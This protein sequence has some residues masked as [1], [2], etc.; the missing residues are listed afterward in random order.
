MT[1]NYNDTNSIDLGN[2]YDQFSQRM[3]DKQ[4]DINDMINNPDTDLTNVNEAFDLQAKMNALTYLTTAA[5]S[6]MK[7]MTEMLTNMARALKQ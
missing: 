7:G 1:V 4:K 2:V 6:T 3:F 5:S